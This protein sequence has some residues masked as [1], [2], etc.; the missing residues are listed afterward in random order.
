MQV[1][2]ILAFN[3]TSGEMTWGFSA[4]KNL[5]E[6]GWVDAMPAFKALLKDATLEEY[7]R[8]QGTSRTIKSKQDVI[9]LPVH[10]ISTAFAF[11]NYG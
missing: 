2:S 3:E 10:A 11:T 1:P 7:N 6:H 8:R 9:I 4:K 5:A